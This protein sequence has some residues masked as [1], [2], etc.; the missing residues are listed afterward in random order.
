MRIA[1]DRRALEINK[2]ISDRS[3]H[4]PPILVRDNSGKTSHV[5]EFILSND[6]NWRV[7]YEPF[8]PWIEVAG[9]GEPIA[10]NVWIEEYD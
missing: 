9:D 1:V 5:Y 6:L 3:L 4:H 10:F 2:R 8:E 7:V